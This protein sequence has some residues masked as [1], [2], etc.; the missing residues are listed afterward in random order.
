LQLID[1]PGQQADWRA[2]IVYARNHQGIDPQR[3][4]LW[5]PRWAERM[6]SPWR[7]PTGRDPLLVPVLGEPGTT[8]MF[9]DP[10]ARKALHAKGTE[11]TL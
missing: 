7:R 3:I 9:T 8:A 5:A 6:P 4:A 11:G 2:A 10:E 1:I